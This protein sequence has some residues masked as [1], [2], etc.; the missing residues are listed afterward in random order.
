[1]KHDASHSNG[2]PTA[3]R[4]YLAPP[5]VSGMPDE[6]EILE[7]AAHQVARRDPQE[8]AVLGRADAAEVEV[9]GDRRGRIRGIAHQVA[10]PVGVLTVNA[11]REQTR[12]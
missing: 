12:E 4:N 5:P 6:S 2:L 7:R 8:P 3:R 11:P 1:M 9:G 10:H